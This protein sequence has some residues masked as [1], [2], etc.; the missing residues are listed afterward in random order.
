MTIK[1]VWNYTCKLWKESDSV[2]NII[3]ASLSRLE[4]KMHPLNI[5]KRTMK[6]G[7]HIVAYPRYSICIGISLTLSL[8]SREHDSNT[9][10]IDWPQQSEVCVGLL[11]VIC[12][13]WWY[14]K[15]EYTQYG[16]QIE[17]V[18]PYPLSLFIT[19]YLLTIYSEFLGELFFDKTYPY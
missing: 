19:T 7:A 9:L 10:I 3:L 1:W 13:L 12:A 4:V 18:S 11:L 5:L 8:K 16:S 2:W 15:F 14:R 6:W 17:F